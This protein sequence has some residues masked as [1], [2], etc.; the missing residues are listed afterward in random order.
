MSAASKAKREVPNLE[1]IVFEK[2]DIVSFGLCG[3]PYYIS[4]LIDELDDLIAFT[5]EE[6]R[7]NRDIDV[8]TN[9]EVTDINPDG[10]K[11]IVKNENDEEFEMGYDKLLIATG[12]HPKVPALENMNLDNIFTLH[13]L[14]DG[15]KV[16]NFIGKE[17]PEKVVLTAGYIGLEMAEAFRELGLDVTVAA[18][19]EHVLPMV[20]EEM[21]EPIEQELNIQNVKLRK[22]S[23]ITGFQGDGEG[24]VRKVITDDGEI[25]TDFVLLS[26]GVEPTTELAENAGVRIGKTD[27]IIV[28]ERM[29]TSI[30]DIYAAGDCVES[31]NIVS[32][33]K[34]HIPLGD[35]ANRQGRVAGTNIVGGNASFPGVLG[36]AITKIFD[37][38][39]ARTGLSESKAEELGYDYV[40]PT[41]EHGTRAFYYPGGDKITLK[42][43]VERDSGRIL[44]AQMAGKEGVSQRI[45][46]FASLIYNET[47]VQEIQNLDFAYAPPYSPAWDPIQTIAKVA[48]SKL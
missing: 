44:G 43:I 10:E 25:E 13:W 7:E 2:Q 48:S 11:V 29:E 9:H 27:G 21:A 20:D 14:E 26:T 28:D 41:I 32:G 23:T 33:E 15:R 12:A 31:Y 46:V 42:A 37:L 24:K 22:N 47:P 18:K 30:E 19:H 39:M 8:R 6:F 40:A 35:T 17:T 5:P 3:I 45:N 34:V 1:V 36:T 16:K 4:G 38:G